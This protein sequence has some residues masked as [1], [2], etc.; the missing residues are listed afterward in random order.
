MC[1]VKNNVLTLLFVNKR[2]SRYKFIH[3][4]CMVW[5][6]ETLCSVGLT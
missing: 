2:M 5:V 3:N 6:F 1:V 4:K